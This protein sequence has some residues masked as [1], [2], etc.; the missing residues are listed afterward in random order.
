MIFFH[1]FQLSQESNSL[2]LGLIPSLPSHPVRPPEVGPYG[3][4]P[5]GD[6]KG[7]RGEVDPGPR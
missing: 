6:G 2:S 7:C 4:V 1:L 3:G 5:D